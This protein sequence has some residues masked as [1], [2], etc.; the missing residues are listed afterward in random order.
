MFVLNVL[1][2]ETTGLENVTDI[3]FGKKTTNEKHNK[4]NQ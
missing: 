4:L 1:T 3:E 2:A